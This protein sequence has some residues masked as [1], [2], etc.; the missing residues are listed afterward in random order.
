VQAV[1]RQDVTFNPGSV[2]FGVVGRGQTPS[3]EID[4]EY[5]GNM[6]WRIVEIV[7]SGAAPFKVEAEEIYRM[8]P[9]PGGPFKGAGHPGRVGYR[10]TVT[11]KGD[12]AGGPFKQELILKTNDQTSPVFSIA[13]EGNI[14]S[15][16]SVAPQVVKMGTVKVGE[17]KTQKVFVRGSR[18]FRITGV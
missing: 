12:A 16:L 8:P 6:N 10:L 18:P 5:A 9:Q 7:K 11:L 4:V 3:K 15:S 17:D 2:N 14:Q 13:V 1:A